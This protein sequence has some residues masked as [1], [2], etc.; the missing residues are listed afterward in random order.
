MTSAA[1]GDASL[2]GSSSR[3]TAL[4]EFAATLLTS[5]IATHGLTLEQAGL[6]AYLRQLHTQ[7]EA[8]QVHLLE[9]LSEMSRRRA[10]SPERIFDPVAAGANLPATQQD[11][12][13][14]LESTRG[15]VMC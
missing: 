6:E 8:L 1:G 3:S 13:S 9:G 2:G 11:L 5:S 10:Y 12:A 15:A 7:P 4:D 14:R